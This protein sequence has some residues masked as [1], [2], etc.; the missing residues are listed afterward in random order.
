MQIRWTQPAAHDLTQICDYIEQHDGPEAARRVGLSILRRIATLTS[1]PQRGR[2]GRKQGTRELVLPDLPYL[3]VYRIR[4]D[5]IEI[6]RILHGAQKW[7]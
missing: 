3:A 2:L 1:F 4:E 6:S 7:P 5:V